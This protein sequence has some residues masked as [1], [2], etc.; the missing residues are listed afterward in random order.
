MRLSLR[1]ETDLFCQEK[2]NYFFTLKSFDTSLCAI[3][4]NYSMSYQVIWLLQR[5]N[6]TIPFELLSLKTSRCYG[7]YSDLF[8]VFIFHCVDV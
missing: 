5:F 8:T 4:M 1:G 3:V 2:Q 6:E 7:N